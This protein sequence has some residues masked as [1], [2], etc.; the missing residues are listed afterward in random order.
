N[1][2]VSSAKTPSSRS[3]T[4][5]A[6]FPSLAF[7]LTSRPRMTS[8]VPNP[9]SE[10]RP[11]AAVLEPHSAARQSPAAMIFRDGVAKTIVPFVMVDSET[12]WSPLDP[13]AVSLVRPAGIAVQRSRAL[14][15]AAE[16]LLR[17]ARELRLAVSLKQRKQALAHE[18]ARPIRR[19]MHLDLALHVDDG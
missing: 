6:T 18:H 17:S 4:G 1:R 10:G 19:H 11:L 12:L 16:W 14:R 9:S 3:P 7:A 2:L 13:L 15:A 8:W 5:V